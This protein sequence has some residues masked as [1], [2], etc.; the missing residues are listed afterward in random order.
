[1]SFSKDTFCALPWLSILILPSGDFTICALS[2]HTADGVGLA[3]DDSGNVMNILTHSIKDA[4]NSKWHKE[5][6]LAHSRNERH[7]NCQTCWAKDDAAKTLNIDSTSLRMVRSYYQAGIENVVNENE[8][9]TD[10]VP[11][12]VAK[13]LLKA[14]GSID[15]MPI[16]L[17]IRFSNLCNAKCIMCE[18]L[19]SNQWYEDHMLLYNTDTF[20]ASSKKYKIEKTPK[21]S[22]GATYHSNMSDW[23]DDPRWWKQFDEMAPHLC[24]VYITGGE[25]FVQPT[26]D[27][28]IQKLIDR[29]YAKNIVL[30]Y[31]TNL[32]VL[33]P[34]ILNML[35]QFKDI[36]IRVSIDD[37]DAGY[38]LIRYPLKFDR[39]I[40]NL[41]LLNDYGLQEKVTG[42]AV[43]VGMHSIFA[44]IRIY[45]RFQ[46]LQLPYGNRIINHVLRSPRIL[47]IKHFP[48]SIKEQ[49]IHTYDNSNLPPRDKKYVV[50][51]L[52]NTMNDFTDDESRIH[53]MSFVRYMDSLDRLR[54]TNWKEAFPDVTKM[55]LE[56]LEV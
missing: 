7:K 50:G 31:C 53:I 21:I 17:D 18:P 38:D 28:F 43:C 45:D 25:P 29:D 42:I 36:I 19:Y 24:H 6:R 9:F 12:E 35:T 48:K 13:K 47:D 49:I 5:L 4:M 8:I 52:K 10:I 16:S 33:N 51:Y 26:H 44:P 55:L 41:K 40:A 22:G 11:E 37:V 34:K 1:M 54:G 32:S 39:I 27:Q 15:P 46:E 2:G 20:T 14:D 30:E 23:N 3:V 56:F